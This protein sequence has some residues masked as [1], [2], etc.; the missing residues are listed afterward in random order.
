MESL[1]VVTFKQVR[2]SQNQPII[3]MSIYRGVPLTGMSVLREFTAEYFLPSKVDIWNTG[4]MK[5]AK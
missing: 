5:L 4:N 2:F 1:P 3:I